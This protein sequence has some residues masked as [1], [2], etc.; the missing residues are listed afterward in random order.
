MEISQKDYNAEVRK[1]QRLQNIVDSLSRRREYHIGLKRGNTLRFGVVSDT[2]IGSLSERLDALREFYR[3]LKTE[4]I[5]TVFHCGDILDGHG[6]YRG[7]E[8]EQYALGFENQLEAL[9]KRWPRTQIDTFF[10]TGNHDASYK[11]LTGMNVG[12]IIDRYVP[13]MHF[14]DQD[15]ATV[16]LKTK[17][18][19]INLSWNLCNNK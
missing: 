14:L 10:I 12:K 11:N 19:G 4:G 13:R 6:V 2:H 16:L 15:V 7:Q 5:T 18:G 17:N 1:R 3:T 8:Y 9:V